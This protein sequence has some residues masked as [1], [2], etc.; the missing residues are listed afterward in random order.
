MMAM[1][2]SR[3]STTIRMTPRRGVARVRRVFNMSTAS[4]GLFEFSRGQPRRRQRGLGLSPLGVLAPP[5]APRGWAGS[6]VL[7]HG[8]L[9]G[10]LRPV[11]PDAQDDLDAGQ[12]QGSGGAPR[13]HRP[14][15]GV[16]DEDGWTARPPR[17]GVRED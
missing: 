6:Q 5:P 17:E 16:V 9:P 4:S 2:A 7:N 14:G 15:A 1:R 10:L 3:A 8:Y 11:V 12:R 13:G